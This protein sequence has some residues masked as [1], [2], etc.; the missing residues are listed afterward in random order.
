VGVNCMSIGI[1][2]GT[3]AFDF[4]SKSFDDIFRYSVSPMIYRRVA[5]LPG[6]SFQTKLAQYQIPGGKGKKCGCQPDGGIVF[7]KNT[8]ILAIEAKKQNS[9]GNAIER[10]FKNYYIL[11]KLNSEVTYITFA[12]GSGCFSNGPVESTL[13]LVHEEYNKFY[14]RGASC[15]FIDKSFDKEQ[16][17]KIVE[18][19]LEKVIES[20]Q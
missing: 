6:F 8:P 20:Y 15:F 17:L 3:T 16:I 13:R 9:K 2:L 5:E 4:D 1:Q 11:T 14:L 7:Y 18:D 19:C 12:T 10:W